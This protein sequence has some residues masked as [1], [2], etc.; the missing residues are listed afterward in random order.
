MGQIR[1]YFRLDFSTFWRGAPKCTEIWSEKVPDL[2]HL[3]QIWP[4]SLGQMTWNDAVSL[5]SWDDADQWHQLTSNND[6]TEDNTR[7][8][9]CHGCVGV[10][11]CGGV[12][13]CDHLH[14][15]VFY[16]SAGRVE[17]SDEHVMRT[18]VRIDLVNYS[19]R[20]S[21]NETNMGLFKISF[22]YILA[23]R[24]S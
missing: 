2:S 6:N 17:Q 12:T 21:P 20:Y 9:R 18:G 5:R 23:R 1:D 3:G 19:V 16:K 11:R 24:I 14:L 15:T 7:E 13:G 22:Q 8:Q 4:T 10:T